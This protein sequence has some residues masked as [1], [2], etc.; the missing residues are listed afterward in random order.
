MGTNKK[1]VPV[2]GIGTKGYRVEF[3]ILDLYKIKQL[4]IELHEINQ[5][6][7]NFH[8]D[9]QGKNPTLCM[10]YDLLNGLFENTVGETNESWDFLSD[11]E[12]AE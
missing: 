4:A 9:F 5:K 6:S 10:A 2:Q 11:K 1:I 3:S 12:G 8:G 7:S